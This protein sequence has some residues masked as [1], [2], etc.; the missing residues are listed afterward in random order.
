[1]SPPS[2]LVLRRRQ[3]L[4]AQI[5]AWRQQNLAIAFVPTMGAIHDGHLALVKKARAHA[6]RVLA[7]IF[8]NPTQFSPNEDLLIYPRQEAADCQKLAAAGCHLAYCPDMEEIYPP[9]SMTNIH[10]EGL[11]DIWEGEARPH[12]FYGVTKV[13]TRLF[14][15]TQPDF[16]VFGEKDFQQLRIIERL[17]QDL[18]FPL[19]IISHETVREADG[20][21]L[22]S[23]N[24][25]LSAQNRQ[26]AASLPMA[27]YRAK[28]RME[29][30]RLI[31]EA[32]QEARRFLL[33]NGAARIDYISVVRADTL[34]TYP[35]A[36][37]QPELVAR[38]I[39]AARFGKT[40]LIDN[41]PLQAV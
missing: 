23:R 41:L 32:L 10:V 25:Y 39:C 36:R 40:R 27:L 37:L 34:D 9:G 5:T 24:A 35:Y 14:I 12:F 31:D 11:S 17:V 1:M 3:D 38:L 19:R 8:V 16:A 18:G 33:A 15:H 26:E 6:D 22:S 13:V 21:A 2:L 20:L 30:G 4:Q 7:S 29:T 28:V